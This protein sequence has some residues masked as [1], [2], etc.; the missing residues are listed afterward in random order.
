MHIHIVSMNHFYEQKPVVA[1]L[2][3]WNHKEEIF[4]KEKNFTE[5]KGEWISHVK[6]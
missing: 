1:F 5:N 6:L 3:A 2:F 4:N